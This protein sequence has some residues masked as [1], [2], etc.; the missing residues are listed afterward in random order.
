MGWKHEVLQKLREGV[1]GFEGYTDEQNEDFVQ[2]YADQR[3]FELDRLWSDRVPKR[4][5][6]ACPDDLDGPALDA[7]TEWRQNPNRNLLVFGPVGTGKTHMA[8][9]ITRHAHM[10]GLF[11]KVTSMVEMLSSL[12]PDG[13]AILSNYQEPQI[14]LVDDLG[15]E[16]L[17]DWAFEQLNAIVDYRWRNQLPMIVTSNLSPQQ[18]KDIAGERAWSRLQDDAVAVTLTGA[19]RR[20]KAA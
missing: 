10:C 2:T 14:L 5:R 6:D 8:Y 16:K 12:R 18:L 1:V 13:G 17:T 15:A 4:F 20:R 7:F 3:W 19:D 11:P 9:A